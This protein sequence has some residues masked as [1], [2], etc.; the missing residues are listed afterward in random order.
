[1]V[2]EWKRPSFGR[3]VVYGFGD[4]GGGF[5]FLFVTSFLTLYYTDVA[6]ISAAFVGTMML[7][8]R[9][10]DGVS[11]ILMGLLIEKTNTKWGKARPWVFIGSIPL[12][13]SAVLVFSIPSGFSN[14]EKNIYAFITYWFM[15]VICFTIVNLSVQAMLPRFSP[16][17]QDR[18]VVRTIINFMGGFE[19]LGIAILTPKLLEAF[20]GQTSQKAWTTVVVIYAM[21]AMICLLIC[22]FGSKEQVPP[23]VANS[24]EM[25]KTPIIPTLKILFKTRCFYLSIFIMVATNLSTSCFSGS[26]VYY[27]TNVLGDMNYYGIL[28]AARCLAF[29]IPAAPFLIKKFG[30]RRAVLT[31][32]AVCIL[33]EVTVACFASNTL[34]VVVGMIVRNLAYMPL[35]AILFTLSAEIVEYIARKDGIRAEGIITSV[36]SFG[37]K[38]GTGLGSAI[39]GWTLAIGGYNGKLAVQS[40]FTLSCITVATFIIPAICTL[41]IFISM[42]CWNIDKQK[43]AENNS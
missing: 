40:E 1:M 16:D 6:G 27:V 8:V 5:V 26:L 24:A 3:K 15:A 20:G 43:I 21:L 32:L 37:T 11:D 30:K 7:V 22:F 9:M 39:F 13:L 42:F 28:S 41:I 17:Q 36:N 19:I 2:T 10:F 31:G 12:S 35:Q 18:T 34:I 29:L 38:V 4:I 14:T 25:S 33:A 23:T